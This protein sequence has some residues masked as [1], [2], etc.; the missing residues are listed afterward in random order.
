[1]TNKKR[2]QSNTLTILTDSD[3][4]LNK[5]VGKVYKGFYFKHHYTNKLKNKVKKVETC[6]AYYE[7]R[8]SGN[9]ARL[10]LSDTEIT[11]YEQRLL[12]K[13]KFVNF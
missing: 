9:F 8:P 3:I 2:Q 5:R 11:V 13:M 4:N 6:F 1:M 12:E 7:Q 10:K